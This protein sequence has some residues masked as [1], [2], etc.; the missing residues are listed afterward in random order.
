MTPSDAPRGDDN[1]PGDAPITVIG[2]DGTVLHPDADAAGSARGWSQWSQLTRFTVVLAL[3]AMFAFG[4]ITGRTSVTTA[5]GSALAPTPSS[6]PLDAADLESADTDTTAT[7]TDTGPYTTD[8]SW[9]MS[10]SD[11]I[12]A[13]D[14]IVIDGSS[15]G[16]AEF[17]ADWPSEIG[18]C[19][20]EI[21][22]AFV[23]GAAPPP[24]QMDVSLI[25]G[26]SAT[27]FTLADGS[28]TTGPD[29]F[30]TAGVHFL[31]DA[32]IDGDSLIVIVG[33]CDEAAVGHV[34]RVSLD[35]TGEPTPIEIPQDTWQATLVTGGD[36]V[37]VAAWPL[38]AAG[39][40]AIPLVAAD[41][42][43]DTATVPVGVVPMA[44]RGESVL[45]RTGADDASSA[46]FAVLD[47]TTNTVTDRFQAI[48]GQVS[49][50]LVSDIYRGF[51]VSVS[52]R[53]EIECALYTYNVD[54]GEDRL[55][56]ISG[57]Y[58][59][60]IASPVFDISPDGTTIAALLNT[61]HTEVLQTD[62][63]TVFVSGN[64]TLALID[65]DD[66]TVT[67][68]PGYASISMGV[69]TARFSDDG[70]WLLVAAS[71]GNATRMIAYTADGE[72][73]YDLGRITGT[74]GQSPIL[75]AVPAL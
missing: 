38:A 42:S 46:D 15:P 66:G 32:A 25:T 56:H 30:E 14:S 53:C 74:V 7:T 2:P 9:T 61:H 60:Q 35:G 58:A 54:T 41:G 20:E 47:T 3:V 67:E 19:G 24:E 29:L 73:P 8:F 69:P 10:L 55:A 62:D 6:G 33:H 48:P 57:G 12:D 27:V 28:A 16:V 59:A 43:G 31:V 71:E 49:G 44:G 39:Y 64:T 63:A 65:T 4:V 51:V 75:L 22:Q 23:D 21:R 45:V 70:Q 37:W 17:L 50:M 34:F 5:P 68:L 13:G 18:A 26:G 36:R 52:A 40:A 11:S 1:D 72:G